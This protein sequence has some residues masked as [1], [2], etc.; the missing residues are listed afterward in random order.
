VDVFL[1]HLVHEKV[2]KDSKLGERPSFSGVFEG[3]FGEEH[4]IAQMA[5]DFEEHIEGYFDV[6]NYDDVRKAYGDVLKMKAIVD[7]EIAH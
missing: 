5:R 4:E 6:V 3:F 7:A 2:I 1:S